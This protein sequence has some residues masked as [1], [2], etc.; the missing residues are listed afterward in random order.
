MKA[1]FMAK[2]KTSSC[3]ALN[4]LIEKNV[5]VPFAVIPQGNNK[6]RE[7]CN[8]NN[9]KIVTDSELYKLIKEDNEDIKSID[10]V[11]SFLYWKIIK[12]PLINLGKVG[13]I[14]FHPAPLPDY[15][16]VGGYNF[17]ILNELKYWGVS[18]HYVDENIDTGDIIQ[19]NEFEISND[20]TVLELERIS[21]VELLKLFK[22]IITKILN[23]E[24]LSSYTQ[25]PDQGKYISKSDLEAAKEVTINS[26][27][28][29]ID[30]KIRAFW[31]PPYDGAYII[32]DGE[33]YTLVNKEMLK[34]IANNDS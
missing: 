5:E 3:K 29:E 24:E 20:I 12:K 28:E 9:I 19:V 17:A 11:I 7:I 8:K 1:I 15:R 30:K 10:V 27:Q 25:S 2:N 6:L 14:N 13:C 31:F 22:A 23:D 26:S 18:A 16:G 34:K 4:F 21:Q 32:I 33:K